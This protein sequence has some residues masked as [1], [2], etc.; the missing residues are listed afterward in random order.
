MIAK[1][2]TMNIRFAISLLGA[3]SLAF[4][5]PRL[6][7]ESPKQ[8]VGIAERIG[9]LSPTE[10][11]ASILLDNGTILAVFKNGD[12]AV[13][14]KFPPLSKKAGAAQEVKLSLQ[15]GMPDEVD[16]QPN[17]PI[18]KSLLKMTKDVLGSTGEISARSKLVA[19]N[20]YSLLFDRKTIALNLR[21]P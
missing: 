6:F 8:D 10:I 11:D 2:T 4:L 3:V 5:I 12:Q 7:G 15:P 14:L 20:C 1:L 19:Q 13:I 17:S 9:K 21:W 18:E 16:V